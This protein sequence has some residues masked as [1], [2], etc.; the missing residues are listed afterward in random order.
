MTVDSET[1]QVETPRSRR[2]ILAGAAGGLAGLILGGLG[3]PSST[4]AAA[5]DP[6]ILGSANDAGVSNTTVK[7][8][9]PSPG[10]ALQM[11]NLGTG[12][13]AFMLS[14]GG[15][16]LAAQTSSADKYG[17]SVTN[18]GLAGGT[19][20]AILATGKLNH[21]LVATTDSNSKHAIHAT[22]AN[23]TAIS[24]SAIQ[25]GVEGSAYR[26]VHGIASASFAS[27]GVWGSGGTGTD[28]YGVVGEVN[29]IS[30]RG[31]FGVNHADGGAGVYGQ[32]NSGGVTFDAGNGVVG[33]SGGGNNST[34]HPSGNIWDGAG[35]FVGN[36]GVLARTNVDSGYAIAGWAETAGA[37][38]IRGQAVAS[39]YAGYFVG[40]A[41]VTGDLN[42]GGTLT[43]GAGTFTIDHP[44]DPARKI[45]S[46]SFVESPDMM[47]VYNG[48]V[49]TD[50]KGEATIRLPD[51]FEALNKDPRYQLTAVGTLAQAIVSSK[52]KNNAFSIKTDKPGVEVSWQVTGIRKDA[53]AEAHRIVVEANKPKD[54]QGLYLHPKEHGQPSS[55]GIAQ[56]QSKASGQMKK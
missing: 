31:V 35:E 52:I 25:I 21:G 7:T 54:Q 48:N 50:S 55:K 37:F 14:T 34:L 40:R 49:K 44:L 42:V 32:N 46:H 2:A 38:A 41:N 19:G 47:N 20:G 13:G 39:G 18:Q 5:G 28:N 43:K 22:G 17:A 24:G 45:L 10:I 15:V 4:N 26:G 11:N 27:A 36:N 53:Y 23:G 51:Y 12:T 1:P 9:S 6:I 56:A 33:L 16:G 3:R 30:G 29:V 8:N